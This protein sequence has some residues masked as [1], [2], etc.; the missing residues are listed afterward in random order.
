MDLSDS[1]SGGTTS[2]QFLGTREAPGQALIAMRAW[3]HVE[4]QQLHA[5]ACYGMN[6]QIANLWL[7]WPLAALSI[8]IT[9]TEVK[10][11]LTIR[12]HA[13]CGMTSQRSLTHLPQRVTHWLAAFLAS[14]PR[15]PDI[16]AGQ[17]PYKLDYQI[18]NTK[19][20]TSLRSLTQILTTFQEASIFIAWQ[21]PPEDIELDVVRC[22]SATLGG[23]CK[24]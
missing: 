19:Q 20:T 9:N 5:R 7:R 15:R 10:E 1:S 22:C 14:F 21:Q 24:L 13:I 17:Q 8:I 18:N 12:E 4:V 11:S 6:G 2:H 3:Q 16:N 23:Y